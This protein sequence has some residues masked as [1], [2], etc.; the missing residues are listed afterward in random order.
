MKRTCVKVNRIA[1]DLTECLVVGG[2]RV[3]GV[4]FAHRKGRTL[5]SCRVIDVAQDSDVEMRRNAYG[6]WAATGAS[7]GEVAQAIWGGGA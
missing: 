7:R 5:M 1:P 6:H 2:Q 4:L 3:V